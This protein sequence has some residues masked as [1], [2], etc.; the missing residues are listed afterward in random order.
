[1]SRRRW[2]LTSAEATPGPPGVETVA[3]S[4]E[5]GVVEQ[6]RTGGA[7]SAG[8]MH[9][10]RISK[11]FES[12]K[13]VKDLSLTLEPG[14]LLTLLGPSG[15][16]K[17]TTLRC[18]AGL[19]TPDSGTIRIGASAVFDGAARRNVP[20]EN[21]RLGMVFQSYAVW[22]HMRVFDNVAYPLTVRRSR[23]GPE[24]RRRVEAM[25]E[26]VGLG[27]MGDRFATNLSGGQQQRVALAR[28]LV[29]NPR[30]V[31]FDE[32]LSNL[33]VALRRE[34]RVQI[35]EIQRKV[36]ISAIYV[37]HDQEEAL[38]LSDQIA[39][40]NHGVVEQL[41][42]SEEVF[43]S[44]RTEFVASFLGGG[45]LCPGRVAERRGDDRVAVR[46]EGSK[47]SHVICRPVEHLDVGDQ[48]TVAIRP[49]AAAVVPDPPASPSDNV[50][51]GDVRL[52]QFLGHTT[53]LYTELDGWGIVVHDP[54]A[55]G[56]SVGE[57]CAFRIDPRL[58]VAVPSDNKRPF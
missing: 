52:V 29:A 2:P 42:P 46:L 30:V 4:T 14:T 9:L 38:A 37:T 54:A 36:G 49:G 40:M 3:D 8:G 5:V 53:E 22:P 32:P 28:A 41:G 18:I 7:E 39:V 58:A 19:E 25:L 35:S 10:E 51:E 23:K 17:T 1:M 57:S 50:F 6:D 45:A 55:Q 16:G 34:M 47:N 48:A 20:P 26:T 13:A 44:P 11:S 12:F 24:T 56:L 15:C 31:L 27:G 43:S 33:D 21:R